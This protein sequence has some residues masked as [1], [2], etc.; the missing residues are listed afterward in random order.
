MWHSFTR[1]LIWEVEPA[2]IWVRG[3]SRGGLG[4]ISTAVVLSCPP[5][6]VTIRLEEV[7]QT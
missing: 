6:E 3:L 5:H 4:Q 2:S 1:C 7:K